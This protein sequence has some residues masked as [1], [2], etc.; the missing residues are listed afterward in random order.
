ERRAAARADD[1]L[2][3]RHRPEQAPEEQPAER[4]VEA[5]E[6]TLH[7]PRRAGERLLGREGPG[8]RRSGGHAWALDAEIVTGRHVAGEKKAVVRRPEGDGVDERPKRAGEERLR[9][10]G[11]RRA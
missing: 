9:G 1:R 5:E 11:E 3:R 6:R 7:V 4:H 8:G 2:V 10:V